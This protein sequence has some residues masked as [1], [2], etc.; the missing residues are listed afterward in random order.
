MLKR[1]LLIVLIMAKVISVVA[2]HNEQSAAFYLQKS[3]TQKT[4][5]FVT[6]GTSLAAL[7]QGI[8]LLG[9]AR[10]GWEQSD[11]PNTITGTGLVVIG[12]SLAFASIVLFSSSHANR[13]RYQKLELVINKPVSINTGSSISVMPYSVGI[14]WPIR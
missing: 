13:K 11:F 12:T 14:N 5:A 2:Q 1:S 4:V 7:V 10:P 3:R 9:Q 6:A 8:I